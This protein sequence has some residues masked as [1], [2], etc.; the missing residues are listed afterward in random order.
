MDHLPAAPTITDFGFETV[1]VQSDGK[2]VAAGQIFDSARTTPRDLV[3]ARFDANGVLDPTFSGGFGHIV[4]SATSEFIFDVARS[5]AIQPHGKIVVGALSNA[6]V[7]FRLL[8][9]I[10]SR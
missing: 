2:I 8:A 1:E 3:V 5:V 4:D 10:W 7:Q 6:D 9:H